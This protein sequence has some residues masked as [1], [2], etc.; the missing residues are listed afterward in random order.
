MVT[1][2][3]YVTPDGQAL[4]VY[5]DHTRK[6]VILTREQATLINLIIAHYEKVETHG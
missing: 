3:I 1:P 4:I 5:P 6:E 2:D